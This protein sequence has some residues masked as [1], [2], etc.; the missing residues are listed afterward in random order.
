MFDMRLDICLSTALYLPPIVTDNAQTYTTRDG[1]VR[2]LATGL[3]F[4]NN[5]LTG[6][7]HN[8]DYGELTLQLQALRQYMHACAP[9]GRTTDW[10]ELP[11][12]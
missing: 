6:I 7:E 4:A 9:S 10:T 12:G 8:E 1:P 3:I 11:T 2:C 5:G